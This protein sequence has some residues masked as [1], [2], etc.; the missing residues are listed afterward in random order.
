MAS[1]NNAIDLLKKHGFQPVFHPS[2]GGHTWENW[3]DYLVI[4][5]GQIF[6]DRS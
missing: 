6:R 2:E 3:R 5:A 1:T 4:F